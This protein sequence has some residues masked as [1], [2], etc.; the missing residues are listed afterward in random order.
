MFQKSPKIIIIKENRKKK[1]FEKDRRRIL[2]AL[3]NISGKK[4]L[5]KFFC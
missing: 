4:K 2:V 1:V 3:Q 5:D